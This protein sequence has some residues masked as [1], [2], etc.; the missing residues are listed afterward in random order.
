MI[1]TSLVI[2]W[3]GQ[4]MWCI[5]KYSTPVL[6]ELSR[7]NCCVIQDALWAAKCQTIDLHD[8]YGALY[9]VAAKSLEI[10]DT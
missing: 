10:R 1:T 9:F 3:S 2:L 4:Y 8:A 5:K 7:T 6:Y